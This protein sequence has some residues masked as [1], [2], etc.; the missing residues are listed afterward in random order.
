MK[1]YTLLLYKSVVLI[2]YCLPLYSISQTTTSSLSGLIKNESGNVLAGA[3][4]TA[5][6]QPTGYKYKGVS[7]SKGWY[8]MHNMNAGGPYKMEISFINYASQT[9]ENVYLQLGEND[10]FIWVLREDTASLISVG[11]T[12]T[13]TAKGFINKAGTASIINREKLNNLPSVGRN[14]YDF[15]R[16]VPHARLTGQSLAEGISF[17]GQNNRFNSFYVDGAVNND[18]FGLTTSGTNGGQTGIAPLSVDAIDQFQLVISPYDASLGNFTGAGINAITKSGTN[19]FKGSFYYTFRNQD[20]AGKTPTGS[21]SAATKLNSFTNQTT[22]LSMGGALRVNKLFYFFNT[23]LQQDINPQS[24]D[25]SEYMGN[26]KNRHDMQTLAEYMRTTYHYEPGAFLDNR[27][28]LHAARISTKLDWNMSNRHKLSTSFRYTSGEKTFAFGSSGTAIHFYNNGYIV[29]SKTHSL[30]IELKSLVGKAASNKLLLTATHVQDDRSILGKPFPSIT[31]FDGSGTIFLGTDDNSAQNL[32]IQKNVSLADAFKFNAGKHFISVGTDNEWN[33]IRNIFIQR[34]YGAY[35][36][37]SLQQ[38]L[39]NARPA[40][41]KVGYPLT[42]DLLD[43]RTKAA[44]A[45]SI[46]KLALYFN[47]EW[48]INQ[49]LSINMGIRADYY[50]MLTRPLADKFATDTALP[51]LAQFYLIPQMQPGRQPN[52][53]IALSPRI[54][55][56]YTIPEESMVVRGGIGWFTGRIPLVWPSGIYS[57]TGITQ[58]SFTADKTNNSNALSQIVFRPDPFKQYRPT[59]LGIQPT[60]GDLN[61]MTPTFHMPTLLR[62]SMAIDKNWGNGWALTTEILLSK[63]LQEIHYT[64]INILPPTALSE[65]PGTRSVYSTPL[66]IPLRDDGSNPY[67]NILMLSNSTNHKGFAYNFACVLNK[68]TTTGFAF[69]LQYNYGDSYISQEATSSVNASQWQNMETV[70]GNNFVTRSRSDFSAGNTI[71]AYLSKKMAYA[72]KS[73]S[74]TVSLLYTG[75]SGQPFS[76]VYNGAPV[77]DGVSGNNLIYVP[78]E[79]ELQQ[80]IFV[81]N[82]ISGIGSFTPDQQRTAFNNY[83]NN[84]PYLNKQRGQF[85]ERNASRL[86]FTNIID[87]KITEDIQLKIRS[88]KYQ[89]QLSYSIFN[90]GNLLNRNW[91]RRYNLDND[92]FPLLTFAGYESEHNLI[93]QYK[94]NPTIGKPWNISTSSLPAYS[95]RWI[96]QLELRFNIY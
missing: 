6:H 79:K 63:N 91:G 80:M 57:N 50:R 87:A 16:T 75:V 42:D 67:T 52:I 15:L 82:D 90:L 51:K 27:Q 23:E 88:K 93:P 49:N 39:Q 77:R 54:G 59:D 35:R 10:H 5:I 70:N 92:H 11:V 14:L 74:T 19:H 17:A 46:V 62:S 4:I 45:F 66:Q 28:Q 18:V 8:N 55:F 84:D 73:M 21:A 61:L 68:S 36:Y 89:F 56:V 64:N 81:E 94:F 33:I 72:K 12:A 30:S 86:P 7:N 83:I 78:L 44:A 47:D 95:A 13:K 1:P 26:T 37:D 2:L 65:G 31:I 43:D 34:T 24:F 48:R 29:P 9:L 76:Y 58:G 38:F 60:K 69:N 25:F 96:S 41:Y 71:T 53:P 3:V 20:L 22:G 40:Q 85:A 32:L